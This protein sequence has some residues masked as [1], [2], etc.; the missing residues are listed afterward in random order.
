MMDEQILKGKCLY[1][2]GGA[3]REYAAVGCNFYRGCPFQCSYCYNRKG[4]TA[5]VNGLSYAL[6]E[7]S[8]TKSSHRPKK[9][10]DMI[11]TDYA[12][13]VFKGE[14]EKWLD[15][16]LQHGIFF[17]FSTDPLSSD[18]AELTTKAAFYAAQK[19]INVKILTKNAGA[20]SAIFRP[21]LNNKFNSHIAIGFTLTGRDDIEPYAP[22]NAQRIETLKLL[23]QWGLKTFVSI[24]P[25]VDFDSSWKMIEETAGIAD[26]F[27]IGLMS[28]RKANGFE[29]YDISQC[30]AFLHK[31]ALLAMDKG[32]KVYWKE[33]IRAFADSPFNQE[34]VFNNNAFSVDKNW[35]LF[36]NKRV[37]I[38]SFENWQ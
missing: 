7:D 20:T 22:S 38:F 37:P 33:S 30:N 21:L 5:K 9:Y 36:T 18:T 3:A 14:V 19:G 28:N 35:D 24:E 6:L 32:M 13:T 12:L 8:F 2:P 11:P 10:Q 34:H 23:H 15:H 26:Q 16:L 1:T 17:S 25:I 4:L 31:T 27:L 29:P